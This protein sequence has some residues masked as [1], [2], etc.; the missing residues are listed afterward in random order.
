MPKGSDAL[1]VSPEWDIQVLEYTNEFLQDDGASASG[2]QNVLSPTWTTEQMSG[3]SRDHY[4]YNPVSKANDIFKDVAMKWYPPLATDLSNV[5]TDL[6]PGAT[7]VG[8]TTPNNLYGDIYFARMKDAA[9]YADSAIY[10]YFAFSI[11]DY[12][13]LSGNTI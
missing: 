7:D 5:I 4:E 8:T 6:I 13:M 9:T 12:Y 10:N 1:N 2:L 3:A 11:G